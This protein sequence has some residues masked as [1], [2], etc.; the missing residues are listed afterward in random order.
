MQWVLMINLSQKYAKLIRQCKQ[1]KYRYKHSIFLAEG[2]KVVQEFLKSDLNL[3]ALIVDNEA[4]I[5]EHP[6]IQDFNTFLTDAKT[7]K[8]L[9]SQVTPDGVMGVFLMPKLEENVFSN[10]VLILLDGVNDPGNLGTIIRT[11]HWYGIKNIVCSEGS[12]DVYNPKVVQASMGSLGSVKVVYRDLKDV[13][14]EAKSNTYQIFGAL[15]NGENLKTI[16][17]PEKSVWV[18]GSESHGISEKVLA[19][20]DTAIT[21]MPQNPY[22]K[23]ES[24]NLSIAFGTIMYHIH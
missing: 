8:S 3:Q 15:L 14:I 20:I 21:I 4:K 18:F 17:K 24:L 13:L 16:T 11:A 10:P 19:E 2:Q 22:D 1:K 9:S 6:K 12:V 5:F 23:P 7:F